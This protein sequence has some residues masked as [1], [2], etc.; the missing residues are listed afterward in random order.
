MTQ[1]EIRD[2]K[3]LDFFTKKHKYSNVKLLK[4]MS[5]KVAHGV[6]P[7][8]EETLFELGKDGYYILYY[9]S[10]CNFIILY[11]TLNKYKLIITSNS[12]SSNY[13]EYESNNTLFFKEYLNH[14]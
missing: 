6:I 11:Y 3:L 10:H 7:Y 12:F 1:K 2:A 9:I 4:W 14:I 5:E 13:V 8:K